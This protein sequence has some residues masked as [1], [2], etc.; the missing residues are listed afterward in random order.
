MQM[1]PVEKTCIMLIERIGEIETRIHEIESENKL[2][3]NRID[4][5]ECF[6]RQLC[7]IHNELNHQALSF[8]AFPKQPE[9]ENQ[10]PVNRCMI[11]DLY[12]AQ[13]L[14]NSALEDLRDEFKGC[15]EFQLDLIIK[16]D[17]LYEI[18]EQDDAVSMIV[19]WKRQECDDDNVKNDTLMIQKV[20]KA[21]KDATLLIDSSSI[22]SHW[23][24]YELDRHEPITFH[25]RDKRIRRAILNPRIHVYT[26]SGGKNSDVYFLKSIVSEEDDGGA[27]VE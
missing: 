24:A 15:W 13:Y 25:V 23:Y 27:L 21:I 12:F 8:Y 16:L 18:E 20:H 11:A 22:L 19:S 17:Q 7:S 4:E 14:N 26:L 2:L 3:K 10:I 1:T 6:N 5:M 9:T